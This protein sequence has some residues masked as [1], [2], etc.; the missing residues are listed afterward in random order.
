MG[1]VA[2]VVPPVCQVPRVAV[3]VAVVVPQVLQV[4]Q[5]VQVIIT[6]DPF[7]IIRCCWMSLAVSSL[8]YWGGTA[9]STPEMNSLDGSASRERLDALIEGCPKKHEAPLEVCVA[10]MS[11]RAHDSLTR[12]RGHFAPQLNRFE[13]APSLDHLMFC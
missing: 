6:V 2:V 4:P 3:G 10:L 13:M 11:N 8:H 12:W 7:V 1:G 5:V 9:A